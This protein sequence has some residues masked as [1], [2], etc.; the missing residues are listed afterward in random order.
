[1]PEPADIA[2]RPNPGFETEV[3]DEMH[4]LVS[5]LAPGVANLRV[6]RIPGHPDWLEP[7]FEVTPTNQKAAR[8]EG[9]A[10][11]D[12]LSLVIGEAEREFPGFARGGSIIRGASWQRELRWIWETVIAGGFTQHHYLDSTGN[13]IG[14][15]AKLL[16]NGNELVFR[17]G[18]RAERLFGE[19]K[20]RDVTYEPY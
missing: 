10:V 6:G 5:A 17:N 7:Y 12:D 1:M 3:L 16:V 20:V 2:P 9:V 13:V 8:L 14:W 4:G 11:A 18:R 19:S 15:S